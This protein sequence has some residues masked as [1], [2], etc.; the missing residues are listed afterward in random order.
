MNNH[1]TS[2][3]VTD[4]VASYGAESILAFKY[5]DVCNALYHPGGAGNNRVQAEI[6]VELYLGGRIH[7]AGDAA[8]EL[9]EMFKSDTLVDVRHFII[10]DVTGNF[11]TPTLQVFNMAKASGV[12]F[13]K[14]VK[15][16]RA[17]SLRGQAGSAQFYVD[18][19]EAE[20]E[21]N[22]FLRRAGVT[23][24]LMNE[25]THAEDVRAMLEVSS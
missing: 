20:A 21:W 23:K 7:L 11:G 14:G 19:V 16:R 18:G 25:E 12:V 17:A 6:N 15:G 4:A 1:T 2:Y 9:F 10:C 24:L 5:D 8:H 22:T 13:R 3:I